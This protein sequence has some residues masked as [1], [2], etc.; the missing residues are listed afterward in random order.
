MSSAEYFKTLDR[1]FDKFNGI[2]S[3]EQY[4]A[5]IDDFSVSRYVDPSKL[6]LNI[7]EHE[8][9]LIT[10]LDFLA[11]CQKWSNNII[12]AGIKIDS[13]FKGNLSKVINFQNSADIY[14]AILQDPKL[15]GKELFQQSIFLSQQFPDIELDIFTK[16]AASSEFSDGY[17][18]NIRTSWQYIQ[19]LLKKYKKSISGEPEYYFKKFESISENRIKF[20]AVFV[21]NKNSITGRYENAIVEQCWLWLDKESEPNV[22]KSL[23][24]SINYHKGYSYDDRSIGAAIRKG[25]NEAVELY[26]SVETDKRKVGIKNS[27]FR[28][29]ELGDD[30]DGE[31]IGAATLFSTLTYLYNRKLPS[32]VLCTGKI[33]PNE[34]GILGINEKAKIGLEE[35]YKTFIMPDENKKELDKRF[36]TDLN[37]QTYESIEDLFEIWS[38]FFKERRGGKKL[39]Q[40]LGE[41]VD[42]ELTEAYKYF[43]GPNEDF[44]QAFS[45]FEN[46]AKL[47]NISAQNMLGYMYYV[48]KGTNADL[49]KSLVWYQ[50]AANQGC[51]YS[52]Y[53]MGSIMMDQFYAEGGE[54]KIDKSLESNAIGY[55]KKSSEQGY[56]KAQVYLGSVYEMSDKYKPSEAEYWYQTAS[57]NGDVE[58]DYQLGAAHLSEEKLDRD[59]EK[60]FEYFNKAAEKEYCIAQFQLAYLYLRGY[61]VEKD[62]ARAYDLFVKAALQGDPLALLQI[63]VFNLFENKPKFDKAAGM[64]MLE[65]A[66]SDKMQIRGLTKETLGFEVLR[67]FIQLFKKYGFFA[68]DEIKKG[69][70]EN[71]KR[72]FKYFYGNE[73][74][75]YLYFSSARI[76]S[77]KKAIV[78]GERSIAWFIDENEY[79]IH[80]H[81][82]EGFNTATIDTFGPILKKT[83]I[84]GKNS[85]PSEIAE[86]LCILIQILHQ[87]ATVRPGESSYQ[88]AESQLKNMLV[89]KGFPELDITIPFDKVSEICKSHQT[90]IYHV[91]D[92]LAQQQIL[93]QRENEEM[94]FSHQYKN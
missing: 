23:P 77:G 71:L 81:L 87:I 8:F 14:L 57:V 61:G 21:W 88:L 84:F 39:R 26:N 69:Q 12:E 67:I 38:G 56:T 62:I 75:I 3:F 45:L 89:E 24:I 74:K 93:C 40:T 34:T 1:I 79:Y 13:K 16:S 33:D 9:D 91:L 11:R 32:D 17:K 4:T 65:V 2:D 86:K 64:L 63:A 47:G 42:S 20:P 55:L 27:F 43:F 35:K 5:F 7:V 19:E 29:G 46:D 78:I 36:Y 6:S 85:L 15:N 52:Q 48:G 83:L 73:E 60:A 80:P 68:F 49:K 18:K 28:I 54:S 66:A 22:E 94:L 31:S 59:L 30:Y 10:C 58:A 51:P 92:N 50:K 37:I 76:K 72:L 70:K 90:S 44:Y 25:I 53:W 82:W 41:T